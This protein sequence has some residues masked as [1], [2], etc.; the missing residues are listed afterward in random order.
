ML[1]ALSF[2]LN[3]GG[4]LFPPTFHPDETRLIRLAHGA[5]HEWSE[6]AL[7]TYVGRVLSNPV[8]ADPLETARAGRRVAAL[9]GAASVLLLWRLLRETTP[10]AAALGASAAIAFSPI[11]VSAAHYFTPSTLELALALSSLWCLSRAIAQRGARWWLAT[12]LSIGLAMS[13]SYSAICL[14]IA[15]LLATALTDVDDARDY[16]RHLAKAAVAAAAIFSLVNIGVLVD[17]GAIPSG[18]GRELGAFFGGDH[19]YVGALSGQAFYLREVL[20]PGFTIPVLGTALI[21]F[22]L[23]ARQWAHLGTTA[24]LVL[25]YGATVYLL[26]ELSPR[27]P[28]PGAE[29]LVLPMMAAVGLGVALV[30]TEVTRRG[31]RRAWLLATVSVVLVAVSLHGS[32][33]LVRG[34]GRDTRLEA[35]AWLAA[36]ARRTLRGPFTSAVPPDV[37]SVASVDLDAARRAG[38]THVATSSFVYD[39]FARGNLLAGQADYVYARHERYQEL[40]EYPYEEFAPDGPGF[41]WSQPTVRVLDIRTPRPPGRP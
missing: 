8:S 14:L 40:F 15:A 38:I 34:L 33:Q 22:V 9:F 31:T 5:A 25:L 13:A 1:C 20:T 37:T 4:A 10:Q 16:L 19:L 27:K 18:P 23:A 29:S 21:G 3:V 6:P 35:D 26:A 30:L 2:A 17:P 36:N 11:L 32:L 12:G 28:L 41:G 7:M 39:T 24:R